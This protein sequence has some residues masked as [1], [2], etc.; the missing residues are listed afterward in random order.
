MLKSAQLLDAEEEE[1]AGPVGGGAE[2]GGAIDAGSV[3]TGRMGV[4]VVDEEADDM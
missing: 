3:E 4:A 2:E 1:E